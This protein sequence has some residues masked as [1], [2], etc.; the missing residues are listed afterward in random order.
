[1]AI[2]A[3]PPC[4]HKRLFP[5]SAVLVKSITRSAEAYGICGE[6]K[7][8]AGEEKGKGYLLKLKDHGSRPET[9]AN[10]T[11]KTKNIRKLAT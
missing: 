3:P 1:M 11:S 2:R 10:G 5:W 4:R 6:K 7:K 9:E 8:V